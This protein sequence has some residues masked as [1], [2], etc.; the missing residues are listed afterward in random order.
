MLIDR[1][2]QILATFMQRDFSLRSIGMKYHHILE[3]IERLRQC[4]CVDD[5]KRVNRAG[6]TLQLSRKGRMHIWGLREN[7]KKHASIEI[8]MK[9]E[10][11]LI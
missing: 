5:Y 6:S 4:C 1:A 2:E 8:E 3:E 10:G 11:M 9:E 7:A